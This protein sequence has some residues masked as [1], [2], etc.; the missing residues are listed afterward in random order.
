MLW[1]NDQL[2][3][4]DGH[5]WDF[6]QYFNKFYIAIGDDQQLYHTEIEAIECISFMTLDVPLEINT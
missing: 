6:N 1:E 2:E 3:S 4:A 5:D